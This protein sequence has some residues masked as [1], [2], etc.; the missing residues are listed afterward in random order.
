LSADNK[1]LSFFQEL[2]RRN[3]YRVGVAY[4]VLTWLIL[5]VID[6]ITPIFS[7]PDFAPKL[8]LSIL[9]VAFPA[10]LLF[11]WAFEL[12]PEGLKREKDVDRTQSITGNTGQRLDRITIGVLVIA[13]A[14]LLADKFFLSDAPAPVQ[15]VAESSV[16]DAVAEVDESPSIAV[17][18][19]VNM[20]DDKS[21]EYFSDG[22]ADTMLHMLAQISEIRV[23]AR[24]S[25]FQFRDQTMD[26][27]QIG[28]QLNVGTVLEGSV[29]RAGDKI[30]VTAQLIDVENGFHLWSGNFDR[31]LEDV[32]A[33]QDEIANEVV[34]ALKV[35]LLGE[36]AGTMDRDQTEN[37]DAYT[38]YLLAVNALNDM[39]SENL[40]KAAAHLQAAV[41]LD[42]NY[43]RAW[44]TLGRTYV[45]MEDYGV[46]SQSEAIDSAREAASRA[47]D[48]VPDSS[49]ALAVLGKVEM[50]E[51]NRE[52]AGALLNKAVENGPNDS[53]AMNY[54]ADY[55]MFE[56]RPQE[57]LSAFQKSVRMDP[58]SESPLIELSNLYLA[59]GRYDEAAATIA[60]VREFNPDSASASGMAAAIP[61]LQGE[62]AAAITLMNKTVEDDPEDPE[63]AALLG[64]VHLDIDIPNEAKRWFDRAV[65]VDAEHPVTRSAPLFLFYKTR[66]NP[67]EN[68]RLAREL[69]DDKIDNRRQSRS[70]AL[71]IMYEQALAEGNFDSY[72]EILDN[73]YPHL[74]D[75]PPHDFERSLTGLYFTGFALISS[76]QKERGNE[77]LRTWLERVGA[78]QEA[79][80]LTSRGN[81]AVRLMLDDREGALQKLEQLAQRMYNAP[82][83]YTYF[84]L[85]PT[86]DPIREEPAFVA[87]LEKY[88]GNAAEQ[89]ELIQAASTN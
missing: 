66:E 72:F 30:R 79:Y 53:V 58:L 57:A 46:L 1:K 26:I 39:S 45:E 78:V 88:E 47:L 34:A 85:D 55:L 71:R 51:G 38:E 87:L 25:S 24:T 14:M 10:V 17:L 65:E 21:S 68:L 48:I 13:V 42:R 22:L 5:Q 31:D 29:Q 70:I 9:A 61:W 44:A 11:A 40:S 41:A 12:T 67:E 69:L 83:N 73:L 37:F 18:P 7:L 36:V 77:L 81:V 63:S 43:A 74:F 2:K 80:G 84:R 50:L 33:I 16:P 4:A 54:L 8:V 28:E 75:D 76:G 49:E 19:F 20:S 59:L 86:Y 64:W 32:F 23:A 3:V 62:Y 56:G 89:R 27:S 60:R 52:Q 6:T 82:L 15:V 35:S